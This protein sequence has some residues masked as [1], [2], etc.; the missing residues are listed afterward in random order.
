MNS[1][2]VAQ[3]YIHSLPDRDLR[4]EIPGHVAADK[5]HTVA[6]AVSNLWRY[7]RGAQMSITF[8]GV[9][10]V[11]HSGGNSAHVATLY[12]DGNEPLTWEEM[13]EVSKGLADYLG[14]E[15]RMCE[16]FIEQ[17]ERRRELQLVHSS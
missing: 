10:R 17:Q 8:E 6:L 15:L 1:D 5:I 7:G 2:N 9:I 13:A 4:L 12:S 11:V 14:A 3:T 16:W